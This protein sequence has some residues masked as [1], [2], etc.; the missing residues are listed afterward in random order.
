MLFNELFG[1]NEALRVTE[2][3]IFELNY[4]LL[5]EWT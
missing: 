3:L 1:K 4:L 2:K 5:T